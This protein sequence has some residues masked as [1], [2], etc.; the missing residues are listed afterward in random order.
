M[1]V[2]ANGDEYLC[3]PFG[4]MP[5]WLDHHSKCIFSLHARAVYTYREKTRDHACEKTNRGRR[6]VLGEDVTIHRGYNIDEVKHN[7]Q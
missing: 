2:T 1:A 7:G 6:L 3:V 5:I 4:T